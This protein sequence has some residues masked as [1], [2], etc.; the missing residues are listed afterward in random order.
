M[1]GCCLSVYACVCG[2]VSEGL[3]D[4]IGSDGDL[5]VG[6]CKVRWEKMEGRVAQVEKEELSV[7]CSPARG[8][9]P[10]KNT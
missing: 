5:E 3:G 7:P 6:E 8:P 2:T 4:V 1:C 10:L 9:R